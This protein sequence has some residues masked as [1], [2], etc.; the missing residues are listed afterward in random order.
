MYLVNNPHNL[1]YIYNTETNTYTLIGDYDAFIRHLSDN[2]VCVEEGKKNGRAHYTYKKNNYAFS[3]NNYTIEDEI[4]CLNRYETV[5]RKVKVPCT[6]FY[7]DGK[8][9]KID[10]RNFL[11]EA[12]QMKI[13]KEKGACADYRCRKR[14][15]KM[16]RT[17]GHSWLIFKHKIAGGYHR[18]RQYEAMCAADEDCRNYSVKILILD[19]ADC[20]SPE[21]DENFRRVEGNWKS[22]YKVN[23][24]YNIHTHQKD[25]RTIRKMVEDDY[26]PDD[27]DKMLEEAFE[28][29]G[30]GPTR[31][32]T[33]SGA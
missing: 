15:S 10:P 31:G 22:Q 21:W 17:K 29:Q 19:P 13:L 2:V 25:S 3:P 23:K 5:K 4:I 20:Q 32:Q 7:V 18:A 27:I 14:R 28:A 6:Y 11:K 33:P 9:R 1:F 26:S 8:G 16:R 30:L 12:I 24:Q